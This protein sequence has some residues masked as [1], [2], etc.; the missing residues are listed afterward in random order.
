VTADGDGMDAGHADALVVAKLDRL[1][2]SV[3]QVAGGS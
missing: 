3:A 2:R 1:S